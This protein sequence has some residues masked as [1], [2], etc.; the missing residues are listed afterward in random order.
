M[1]LCG[2][3]SELGKGRGWSSRAK[4]IEGTKNIYLVNKEA[5]NKQ[6]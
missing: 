6:P 4:I 2:L 5:I 3:G 1:P